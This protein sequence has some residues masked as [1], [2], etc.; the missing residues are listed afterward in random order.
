M[1]VIASVSVAASGAGTEVKVEVVAALGKDV[2]AAGT[3]VVDGTAVMVVDGKEVYTGGGGGGMELIA[4]LVG[5][6]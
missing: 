4:M 5:M 3:A 1:L 6:E 2:V